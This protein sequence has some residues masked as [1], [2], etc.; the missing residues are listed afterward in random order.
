[1]YEFPVNAFNLML[2]GLIISLLDSAIVH[3][4]LSFYEV[5]LLHQ[6]WTTAAVNDRGIFTVICLISKC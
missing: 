1:M 3:S 4:L 5:L 2:A 6:I